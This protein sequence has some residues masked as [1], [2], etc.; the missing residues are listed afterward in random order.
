MTHLTNEPAD[1]GE[2]VSPEA[3]EVGPGGHPVGHVAAHSVPHLQERIKV[4]V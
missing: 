4:H 2:G 3:V 1:H